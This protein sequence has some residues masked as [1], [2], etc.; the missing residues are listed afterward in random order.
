MSQTGA[1]FVMGRH[2]GGL[3]LYFGPSL[4]AP[5]GWGRTRRTE[6]PQTHVALLTRVDSR[7]LLNWSLDKEATATV[8]SLEAGQIDDVFLHRISVESKVNL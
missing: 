5:T 8:T 2:C 3:L 7:E 4:T 6:L 1:A